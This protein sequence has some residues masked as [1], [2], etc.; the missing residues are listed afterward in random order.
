MPGGF[1]QR[2]AV[3]VRD[4]LQCGD[5]M[6]SRAGARRADVHETGELGT[7]FVDRK[8][9]QIFVDGLRLPAPPARRCEQKTLLARAPA[10]DLGVATSLGPRESRHDH[11][12]EFEPLRAM[13]RHHLHAGGDIG[14][15]LGAQRIQRRDERRPVREVPGD[16]VFCEKSEIALGGA[17]IE[18]LFLH[19][20]SAKR[21]PRAAHAIRERRP[22]P[23]GDRGD[24]ASGDADEALAPCIRQP[25]DRRRRLQQRR[26][27]PRRLRVGGRHHRDE[28][29]ERE[30]APR[31]AQHR[32]PRE[33]I[34][35]LDERMRQRNQIENGLA[36]GQRVELDG[37]I[38]NVGLA[39][40]R[41]YA[42]EMSAR[43]DEHG[44]RPVAGAERGTNRARRRGPLR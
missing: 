5:Q 36:L 16:A 3:I 7:I 14:G 32:K 11:R 44:N 23:R 1:Q 30:A 13:Q 6:E 31:R 8:T 19:G 9:A 40:C 2:V 15:G 28:I 20:A 41:K 42:I 18:C 26:D 37:R 4:G 33:A 39:Q 35:G 17:D 22:A 21:E 24:Q 12:I 29:R 38:G 34:G 27:R 43:A 10:Q 25:G